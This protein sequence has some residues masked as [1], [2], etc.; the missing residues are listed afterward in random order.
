[1]SSLHVLLDIPEVFSSA[2]FTTKI[3]L[4]LSPYA[5][6]LFGNLHISEAP[7]YAALFVLLSLP[8]SAFQGCVGL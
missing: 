3:S 4:R 2:S 5:C 8:P 1:L 7:R 6:T